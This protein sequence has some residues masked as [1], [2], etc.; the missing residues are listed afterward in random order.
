MK[1]QKKVKQAAAIALWHG[2]VC[3]VTSRSG[4]RWVVPKGCLEPGKSADEYV[5]ESIEDP[6]AF[7]VEGFPNAMPSF[8]GRLTDEQVQALVEYLLQT[9]G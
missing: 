1:P 5:R 2:R 7:L 4:K 9:G 8:K 6:G 3:L